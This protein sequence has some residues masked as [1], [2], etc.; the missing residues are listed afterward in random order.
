MVHINNL[1]EK[2]LLIAN[3]F[4][5]KTRK[6][7]TPHEV[8]DMWSNWF[9]KDFRVNG[10]PVF[11]IVDNELVYS[12]SGKNLDENICKEYN[13]TFQKI[14]KWI[15][16]AVEI[17]GHNKAYFHQQLDYERRK[18]FARVVAKAKPLGFYVQLSE[19]NLYKNRLGYF[20]LIKGKK[21]IT[22]G[23]CDKMI[24][25]MEGFKM[26]KNSLADGKYIITLKE[27]TNPFID[28]SGDMKFEY[29]KKY[30]M[31]IENGK[32]FIERDDKPNAYFYVTPYSSLLE[33]FIVKKID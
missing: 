15:K 27:D 16:R 24:E 4:C 11:C 32:C 26:S 8:F 18:E 12:K 13:Q 19:G 2:E 9:R 5:G 29:N 20:K 30:K 10:K 23:D 1:K 22:S 28:N 3:Y 31:K 33:Y 7:L 14:Y 17:D 6:E 25:Y 21:T